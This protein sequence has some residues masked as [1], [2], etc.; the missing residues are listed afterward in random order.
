MGQSGGNPLDEIANITTNVL[1]AGFIGYEN[2]KF[3]RGGLIRAGDEALGEITGRN[4]QR[5]AIYQGQ[6]RLQKEEAN[7]EK[8]LAD[9][10]QQSE[11]KDRLASNMAQ[12]VRN[13]SSKKGRSLYSISEPIN[14][15]RDFLGL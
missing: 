6:V 3:G 12:A 10:Q 7:R 11:N 4:L 2:G 5:E 15:E 14:P 8:M 1:S 13:R 9:E